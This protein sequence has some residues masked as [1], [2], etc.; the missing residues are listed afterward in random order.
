VEGPLIAHELVNPPEMPKPR[1]F[2][3][4]AVAGDT[5]YLA[6]QIGAGETIVEQF[7][8]ALANL[9]AALRG[10]G[11]APDDLISLQVYVTD[12]PAYRESLAELGQ[13]WRKHFGTYYPAIGLF[14][15]TRL[16]EPWAMVEVMGVAVLGSE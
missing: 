12:V 11:G 16:F 7:D 15:V 10:A 5:V 4:A 13:T 1:G 2:S 6:G 8:A 14:G 9:V 3:H